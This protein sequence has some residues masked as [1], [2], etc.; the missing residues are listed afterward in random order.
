MLWIK[1]NYHYRK[2]TIISSFLS[3]SDT[4][5]L[6]WVS[7][8]VHFF[9]SLHT[10]VC[11]IANWSIRII[12]KQVPAYLENIFYLSPN[13]CLTSRNKVFY[14]FRLNIIVMNYHLYP[15]YQY[16]SKQLLQLSKNVKFYLFY[17]IWQSIKVMM[18][19]GK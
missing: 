4:W 7:F 17:Y 14:C 8:D 13:S 9:I 1:I 2:L 12:S 16:N 11:F 5:E 18:E 10:I 3:M 6:K 15:K 19:Y